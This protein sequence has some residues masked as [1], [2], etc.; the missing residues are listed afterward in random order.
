MRIQYAR[1]RDP[2]LLLLILVL[3][4]LMFVSPSMIDHFKNLEVI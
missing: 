1:E 3:L 2:V 4:C